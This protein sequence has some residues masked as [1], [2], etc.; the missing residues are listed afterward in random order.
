[1]KQKSLSVNSEEATSEGATS[2]ELLAQPLG[3]TQD[4]QHEQQLQMA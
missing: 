4:R 2:Q 1:M 3:Y